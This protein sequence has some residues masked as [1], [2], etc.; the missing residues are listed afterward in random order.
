MESVPLFVNKKDMVW[1][2][3]VLAFLFVLS[4][5]WQYHNYKNLVSKP[6]HVEVAKVINHYQKHKANGRVYDVFKL[7]SGDGYTFYTVSW[8]EKDISAGSKVKVK[9][10]TDKITFLSYL[11]NF[12]A[13]SFYIK[14]VGLKSKSYIDKAKEYIKNQ[15]KT[16]ELKELFSALFFAGNISKPTREKIQ[17]LGI[18]HLV[19]ISGFHLGLISA[20]LYFLLGFVYRFFQDR[21]FPY[22]NAKADLAFVIFSLLFFYMYMLDFSPSLLRSFVLSL[23]GF[24]LFS[25]H[26]KI[27]SFA[28]LLLSVGVILIIF[29]KLLFSV[30][31]WFSVSGVF[32][33]FLFLKHFGCLSKIWIF[34]LINIWVFALMMPLVHYIFPMFTSLQLYSPILSMIFTLFYPIELFLH[35]VHYGGLLDSWIE[36]LL[37]LK[38]TVYEFHTP[39]WFLLS[40]IT[41]SFASIFNR[42]LALLLFIL[43]FTIYLI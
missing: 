31:F 27:I 3:F 20:V 8:R 9:F 28:T 34:V 42:R 21:Y 26:I 32:Y 1:T 38:T 19:A 13:V 15:H 25:R 43:S 33:I 10:K 41:L 29:P 22:R 35:L 11:K 2:A 23:F 7:K 16:E 36:N 14:R 18:S 6:L 24:F 12:F 4:L 39:L 5:G 30:S 37:N 40:F 17:K